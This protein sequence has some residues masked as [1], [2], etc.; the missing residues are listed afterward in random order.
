[1]KILMLTPYFPY[2]LVSGG[3]TRT[4]N[5]LKNLA[6]KHQI[7]LFSFIRKDEEREFIPQLLKYCPR[8]EVFK[9]RRAWS[10]FNILTAGV[11]PLPLLVSIYYSPKM[12]K[13]ICQELEKNSYDLIH[14]E[15]F[16]V[17][18]N[19][20]KTEIP[21]L[22]VEQTI[23][24]LVYQ[25]FAKTFPLKVLRPFLY[26]DVTKIRFWEKHYWQKADL[27]AAMCQSDKE[28]M[29]SLVP[30]LHV[31]IVPNGI[32]GDFFS[33]V[34]FQ[35]SKKPTVLFVGNFKWLQNKEAAMILV[36]KIWPQI[37][38]KVKDTRLLIV[39]RNPTVKIKNLASSQISVLE[40]LED[41]REAYQKATLLLAPI[42]GPGG[43]RF[44]IL[45]AMASGTPVVT[46]SVGIE[47]IGAK[48]GQEALICDEPK[49]LAAAAVRLLQDP[50]LAQK[51]STSARK[52]VLE[53]YNWGK[54]AQDLD[55]IY[56]EVAHGRKT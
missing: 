21:I 56:L 48:D 44:K 38:E 13:I 29:E 46:T 50:K 42:K 30:R 26:F 52:L 16:Y 18:P 36:E 43:T 28:I 8:V 9:R 3:Q 37:K 10:V 51:I 7:T 31:E 1:M 12:K 23:E 27:V 35:K 33:E 49:K 6:Q 11:T 45:E 47:G 34:K 55:K 41:I 22:L 15:C 40:N 54:I 20:P 19:L 5:L 14:A 53:K 2:P 32:D 39:G 4:Y 25:H 17:M 24:F